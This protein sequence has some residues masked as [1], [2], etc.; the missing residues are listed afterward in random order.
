MGLIAMLAGA[1][2]A[3]PAPVNL[4]SPDFKANPF[5]FYARLRAEEP[6]ARVT[7][8]TKEEAQI[9]PAGAFFAGF[10]NCRCVFGYRFMFRHAARPNCID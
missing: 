7:L 3:A 2:R 8:P 4:A 1:S 5:P 6:V 9:L 10:S